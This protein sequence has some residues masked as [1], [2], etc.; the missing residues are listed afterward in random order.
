MTKDCTLLV[1]SYDGGE[2]LWEG[3][4]TGLT[5]QWPEL[6]L[7][8]VL[9]TES[10]SYSFPGL[11]IRTLGLYPDGGKD[12]PWGKRLQETLK[13]ID[14]EFV[15]FF[16]EDF[17]LE[18]PVDDA[19]FRRCLRWMRENP[20]VA[21]LSFRPTP[22]PNLQ[23]G[24]FERFERRP[25]NGEYLFNC[26]AA[27]WRRERLISFLRPFES[28]W[29]WE[30][31]GTRMR[32]ARCRDGF[33]SL[34]D[35]AAPVFPYDNGWVIFRGKWCLRAVEPLRKLYGLDIDY[36]GRGIYE[37]QMEK[38]PEQP[39]KQRFFTERLPAS[40]KFRLHKWKSFF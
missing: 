30:A 24:R 11:D 26:Q 37:E 25:R 28:P 22:G 31:W 23:D 19:F 36:S 7:P 1:S 5:R 6:D 9:N 27:L 40:I 14:S 35:G 32:G 18:G 21:N 12:I 39:R 13:R 4:F 34:Q 10:K 2:D 33:Y 38:A 3:F 29:D 15:L 16:L 8:I 17:W 20:D